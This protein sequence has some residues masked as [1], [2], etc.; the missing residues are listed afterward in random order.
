MKGDIRLK[1]HGQAM[2]DFEATMVKETFVVKHLLLSKTL[3]D[4]KKTA[5]LK[6]P[7]FTES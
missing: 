3:E 2:L 1:N 4:L 5:R 6:T 7:C